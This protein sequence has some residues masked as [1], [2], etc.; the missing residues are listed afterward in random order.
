[1][2]G[3]VKH[4]N[5]RRLE[6][7]WQRGKARKLDSQAQS[8]TNQ[9]TCLSFLPIK[10]LILSPRGECFK[11]ISKVSWCKALVTDNVKVGS[12]IAGNCNEYLL[13]ASVYLM[14]NSVKQWLST[15]K[16]QNHY[17]KSYNGKNNATSRREQL[18]TLRMCRY[19]PSRNHFVTYFQDY[20]TSNQVRARLNL[21]GWNPM[22]EIF[23]NPRVYNLHGWEEA[24]YQQS[25][26]GQVQSH[27]WRQEALTSLFLFSSNLSHIYAMNIYWQEQ[28]H[29]R[30]LGH[31]QSM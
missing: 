8:E 22:Y 31:L 19:D 30:Q 17:S 25:P 4:D 11:Q 15:N 1:M 20:T 13:M 28:S 2:D 7:R 26:Q 18:S 24:N 12:A 23:V 21:I 5:M 14:G 9:E 27:F 10:R 29:Q 6:L 3:H 16:S